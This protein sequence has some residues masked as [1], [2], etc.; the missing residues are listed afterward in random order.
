MVATGTA[1]PGSSQ[2][3]SLDFLLGYWGLRSLVHL[4]LLFLDRKSRELCRS[5]ATRMRSN[6]CVD[7]TITLTC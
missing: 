7:A 3:L 2:E 1:G 4:C 5:G 6:A